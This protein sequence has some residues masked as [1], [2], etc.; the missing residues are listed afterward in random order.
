MEIYNK[1]ISRRTIR[2]FKQIEIQVELLKKLVNAGRLA[3]SAM[4]FQPL[5][6]FIATDKQLRDKIFNTLIWAKYINPE[7]NPKEGEEPAAYIIVIFN[8]D[9]A[10]E[11]LVKYD[12]GAS[13]ENI[14]IAALEESIGCCWLKS[15][16]NKK[17]S[18]ILEISEGYSIDSV[19]ALG[20]PLENPVSEDIE[21]D[22][23]IKYYKDPGGRLHV[24]KRKLEDIVHVNRF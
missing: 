10:N 21:K 23:S 20:H 5:E 6:Y 4:N 18:E 14:I 19:L 8:N 3:P 9:L 15:F 2:K 12:V 1:I 11:A 16:D 7:G 22:G 24:P 17:L 13:I